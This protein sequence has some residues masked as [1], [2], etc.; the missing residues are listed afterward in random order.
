MPKLEQKL[1]QKEEFY[2]TCKS[3]QDIIEESN[4]VI[5]LFCSKQILNI[6]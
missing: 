1:T 5:Y 3:E 2:N 4:L 6:I